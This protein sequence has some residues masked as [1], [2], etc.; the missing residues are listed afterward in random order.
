MNGCETNT[1]TEIL[2]C[3]GCARACT[4]R[5]NSTAT[6]E[7][8]TC[9]YTCQAGFGDCDGI[10]ANGCEADLSMSTANCSACGNACRVACVSGTCVTKWLGVGGQHTCAAGAEAVQCWGAND[11]GQLGD[12][13][14]T[15][16]STP[17]RV[18]DGTGFFT[19]LVGV[20]DIAAGGSHTCVRLS[21]GSVRCW[22]ANGSG[23]LGDGSMTA[24]STP[25]AVRELDGAIA[26]AAG[27]S[28]TC[29]RLMDGTVRCWGNNR[30]GQLGDG[31]TTNR[32]TP[33][34]VVG[35]RGVT[36]LDA[37]AGFTCARLSDGTA[38]CWGYNGNNEL[39][40]SGSSLVETTPVAVRGLSGVTNL[41]AG[42]NHACARLSDATVRC[43]GYNFFGELGDGTTMNRT[44]PPVP[45][46][47]LTGVA[48]LTAGGSTTSSFSPTGY[49]CA[50]LSDGTVRCWG[51]GDYGQLGDGMTLDRLAPVPVTGLSGVTE[52]SAG[53]S[54]TCVRLGDYSIRCWGLNFHGQLGDGTTTDR[55]RPTPIFTAMSSLDAGVPSDASSPTDASSPL[56]R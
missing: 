49:T 18:R 34:A 39:G 1:A 50:R 31:T 15:D 22:G 29:A 10:S 20:T 35:L 11:Y 53:E 41:S 33:V 2:H 16:R 45:V 47:S 19:R 43:W 23:Q 6:C 21:F 46:A 56:D 44:S 5:A 36:D 38:R 27:T 55:A 42:F 4:P 12:G 24:A 26:L 17:A 9:R 30:L 52:I 48:D 8:G 7:M 3:G 54:H 40:N 13:T 37:G 28:H 32:T 14:T 51:H 25:I